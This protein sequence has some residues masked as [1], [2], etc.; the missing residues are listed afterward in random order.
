MKINFKK[1]STTYSIGVYPTVELI[2]NPSIQIKKIYMS[3]N[4]DQNKGVQ[5]II[6]YA[7]N[8]NL[9]VSRDDN[10]IRRI[11]GMENAYV[12]AEFY[13][14]ESKLD[15]NANHLLLVNINDMGNTG[16]IL[17]TCLAFNVQNVGLVKP[18]VNIFDPKVV[19]A[20]MGA[21]FKL[22]HEYFDN[23]ESY[24][25]KHHNNIYIL[26]GD[27]KEQVQNISF[28]KPFT[29]VFVGESAG[30]PNNLKNLGTT[31]KIPFSPNVDSLNISV[32]AGICLFYTSNNTY[33]TKH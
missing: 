19:R 15:S 9:P 30:V 26:T 8:K 33:V 13:K 28:K 32:A 20:S 18:C 1:S 23:F 2:S 6:K 14:Y 29:L 24:S 11:S 5:K 10:F 4:S 25:K 7:K 3:S 27:G 16:T 31:V 21:L 12:A 22:K 17:R